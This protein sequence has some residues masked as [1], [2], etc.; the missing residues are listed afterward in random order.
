MANAQNADYVNL[1]NLAIKEGDLMGKA[2]NASKQ[3][4]SSG[5]GA[6]AK[7][8]SNEGHEHQRKKDDYNQQAANWIYNEN[9]KRQPLGSIDLHGL[10]VQESVDFTEKG[11]QN[12]RRNNLSELRVIVGK[13]NHSANHVAKIKPAIEDLMRRENISANIDPNNTG[14]LIVHLNGQTGRGSREILGDME[15]NPDICTIM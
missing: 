10:Y 3:A 4:Y 8:L 11:I 9:N 5:D 14:V 12:A 2:F 1:R 6:R 13:G 7:Q 15:K